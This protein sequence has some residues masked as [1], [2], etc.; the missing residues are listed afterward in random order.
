MDISIEKH[1]ISLHSLFIHSFNNKL[2]FLKLFSHICLPCLSL[3][4]LK[5][6]FWNVVL[7]RSWHWL[8]AYRSFSNSSLCTECFPLL[9]TQL[10]T[11]CM[12]SWRVMFVSVSCQSW[13]VPQF[14]ASHAMAGESHDIWCDLCLHD[15]L[16][17]FLLFSSLCL[18]SQPL[19]PPYIF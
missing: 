14:P 13:P 1:L 16:L 8:E 15:C 12:S 17:S 10:V 18:V 7:D 19:S 3:T 11:H 4:P 9:S 6:V 2:V 5:C